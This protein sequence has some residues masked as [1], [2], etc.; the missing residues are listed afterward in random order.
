MIWLDYGGQRSRSR[1]AVEVA[2]TYTSTLRRRIPSSIVSLVSLA[3]WVTWRSEPR[4]IDPPESHKATPLIAAFSAA[5][6]PQLRGAEFVVDRKEYLRKD[7]VGDGRLRPGC[8][9]LANW[10]KHTHRL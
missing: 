9:N 4:L 7:A 3:A 8:R 6:Q 2:R 5:Q 10:T 1:Q